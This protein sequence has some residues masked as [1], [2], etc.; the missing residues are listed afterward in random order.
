MDSKCLTTKEVARLCRVSDATVKRWEEA[1]LIKSERTSGG[2]RRFRAEEI[3][4]FQQKQQLGLKL[5]HGDESVTT[6]Q[7]RRRIDKKLCDS[8]LFHSLIAGREE[9]VAN[10]LINEFLNGKSVTEIFDTSISKAMVKIGELWL[11]GKLSIAQEHLATRA[12]ICALYKLRNIVPLCKPCHKLAV[13]FAFE[14]DFHELP[15]YLAQMTFESLGWEVINFGA[16]TPVY[17]IADEVLQHSPN[18]VCISSTLMNDIERTSRDYADFL[19]KVNNKD[20]RIFLGGHTFAD[21]K[22][23]HRFA[24]DFYPISFTEVAEIVKDHS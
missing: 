13:C 4:R 23:R 24:A 12:I 10:M 19:K 1:G 16:N 5:E 21:K 11:E 2:H 14:G 22:I 3:A 15:T 8:E 9:E 18:M 20:V 17:A 6:A 7:S